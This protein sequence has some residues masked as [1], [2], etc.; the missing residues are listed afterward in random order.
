MA[1]AVPVFLTQLEKA[2]LETDHANLRAAYAVA[3]TVESAG[4]LEYKNRG[5]IIQFF[6][7]QEYN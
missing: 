2:K 3:A 1:I 4:G 6:P 7:P 5:G